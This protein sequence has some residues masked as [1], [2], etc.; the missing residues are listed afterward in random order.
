MDRERF[1]SQVLLTPWSVLTTKNG[2]RKIC[3]SSFINSLECS[4]DK[5][6]QRKICFS[7][8]INSL[9]CSDDKDGQVTR[10][11]FFQYYGQ[12]SAG[13]EEDAYFDLMV[14][15]AWKL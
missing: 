9:E 15:Q 2:Q 3:F 4:D 13:I 6:G 10:E 12:I 5:D 7:S 14:R 1:A 11:E 8:F